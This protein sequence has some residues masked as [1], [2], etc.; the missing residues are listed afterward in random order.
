[1]VLSPLKEVMT[2]STD[3]EMNSDNCDSDYKLTGS[4]LTGKDD[5]DEEMVYSV[6]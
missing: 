6:M 2:V 4:T 1:M 5:S 3:N